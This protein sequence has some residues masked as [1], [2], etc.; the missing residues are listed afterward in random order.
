M[1]N[2]FAV[3]VVSVEIYNR[4]GQL[5]NNWTDVNKGWDGTGPDGQE[6][7]EGVYFFVLTADGEDGYYYSEEG[8]ITLLR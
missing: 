5:V 6:L 4:W 1:F 2:E 7:P 8:T 3:D